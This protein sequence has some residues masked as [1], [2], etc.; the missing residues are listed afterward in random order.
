[1]WDTIGTTNSA[2]LCSKV[3]SSDGTY[4]TIVAVKFPRTDVKTTWSIAYS[5]MGEP[6][7]KKPA[8]DKPGQPAHFEFAKGWVEEVDRLL[9]QKKLKV[10]RIRRGKGLEEVFDGMDL[11]RKGKVSGQ[12]LVYTL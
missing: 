2:E 9:A 4:G 6:V 5:A 10:H 11:M 3:L 1:V 8:Y 7:Q 12:K